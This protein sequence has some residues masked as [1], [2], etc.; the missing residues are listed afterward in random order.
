MAS[1]EVFNFL[2]FYPEEV[3]NRIE[4]AEEVLKAVGF[5][6]SD[7]DDASDNAKSLI[8]EWIKTG[9]PLKHHDVANDIIFA[10]YDAYAT[11]LVDKGVCE[12]EEDIYYDV[13]GGS[14]SFE[15]KKKQIA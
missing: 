1:N 13:N 14:S 11:A 9:F 12:T 3:E 8:D 4:K 10:F 7:I 15:I 5:T 2:G 6:D